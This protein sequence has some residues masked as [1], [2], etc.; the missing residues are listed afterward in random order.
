MRYVFWEFEGD[1]FWIE[2]TE[3]SFAQ[4]Q[5]IKQAD[6]TVLVSCRQDCLAEGEIENDYI[7]NFEIDKQEFE[8]KWVQYTKKYHFLWEE[9]K[10]IYEIGKKV[11]GIVLYFYPQGIIFS[12]GKIQGIADYDE[13]SKRSSLSNL[14]PHHK[15]TGKVV[16]YDEKN[17]W[18]VI[19]EGY[20]I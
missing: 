19:K 5:I 2:I 3:E 6:N 15:I 17:M 4:R 7:K 10:K 18:I 1:Y 8:E 14:Y 16:G 13:Y 9:A 20:V 11:E 12:I